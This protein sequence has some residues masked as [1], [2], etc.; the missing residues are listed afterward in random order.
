MSNKWDQGNCPNC[1]KPLHWDFVSHQ[2]DSCDCQYA[3]PVAKDKCS[4]CGR[5]LEYDIVEDKFEFCYCIEE[6]QNKIRPISQDVSLAD[7]FEDEIQAVIT[8][9]SSQGLTVGTVIGAMQ[10]REFELKLSLHMP[11][12]I[13]RLAER[14]KK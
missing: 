1:G 12:I 2:Y 8:K 6:K 11:G 4:A 5:K 9:Y 3:K 7:Q 10:N 14:F 13:D